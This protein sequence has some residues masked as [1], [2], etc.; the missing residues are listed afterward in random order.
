MAAE[1]HAMRA[2][3]YIASFVGQVLAGTLKPRAFYENLTS[4]DLQRIDERA[5]VSE[6]VRESLTNNSHSIHGKILI[7][8]A[9]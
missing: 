5:A 3:H 4:A 7:P 6:M 2:G 1:F 9:L 8:E